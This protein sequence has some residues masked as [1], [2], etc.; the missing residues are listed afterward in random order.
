[1]QE[2]EAGDLPMAR[3]GR[4]GERGQTGE[5]KKGGKVTPHASTITTTTTSKASPPPRRSGARRRAPRSRTRPGRWDRYLAKAQAMRSSIENFTFD[6][7]PGN[8]AELGTRA[9]PF[10]AYIT[11][12][13]RQIHKLWTFGFLADLDAK[14]SSNSPYNNEELWTQLE[15][16][17]KGDGTVDKV[18]IVRSSGVLPFDVA[19]IDSVMTAAPFP[20]PPQVIKSANGKV[21]L[22]W[23]FHRNELA[24]GTF[25]VDPHILTTV[26]DN[27]DHDTSV[28][29]AM[30]EGGRKLQRLG[31][32]SAESEPPRP[33]E[34]EPQRTTTPPPAETPQVTEEATRAAEGWFA[35]YQR[36]DAAWLAGWSAAP[37]TAAGE[38]VA[39]DAAGVK[40]MYKQ[41]MGEAPARRPIEGKVEV[42]TPAGIRGKLGGLPPGGEEKGMLY[43]VGTAGGEEF[44]LLLKVSN[45]GW[46][47]CGIDR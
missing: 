31:R 34:V 6:V 42:L 16:V 3:V 41:L 40:A 22:D 18:G 17:V 8:Q 25:N 35:A 26:G 44:I 1:M 20:P 37:L 27:H 29:G 39:K 47:V 14:P 24:C 12:M 33:V 15:I 5:R 30:P 32:G 45:Q 43:A 28:T 23:Q 19:A 9:S 38:I 21:Y 11:A 46:R 2:P 10:A 13:H 4:D 7:K 36:G